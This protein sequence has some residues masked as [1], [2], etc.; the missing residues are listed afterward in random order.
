[1]ARTARTATVPTVSLQHV[2]A[3]LGWGDLYA[4]ERPVVS[5]AFTPAQITSL[6]DTLAEVHVLRVHSDARDHQPVT[7]VV[8]GLLQEALLAYRHYC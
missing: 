4:N 8:E 7:T 2:A 6:L 5:V 1:M 3:Q